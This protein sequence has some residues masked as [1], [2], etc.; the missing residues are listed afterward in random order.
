MPTLEGTLEWRPL[1]E[2]L[3]LVA[4]R[5]AEAAQRVPSAQVAVIDP[6]LSDTAATCEAYDIAPELTANCIVVRGVRGQEETFAA[7]VV[8]AHVRADINGVVRRHLNARKISFA[9]ESIAERQT[10]MIRGGITPIGLPD[11][12]RIIID[13]RVLD[14]DRVLIGAGIRGAK[15][16]VATSELVRLPHAEVLDLAVHG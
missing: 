12:W 10:G 16:I 3:D 5:V 1:A 9:D 2:H 13:Q 7:I 4:R 8:P 6:H 14:H 11:T 15:L